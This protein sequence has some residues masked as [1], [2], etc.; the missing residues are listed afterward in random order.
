M[1]KR[2]VFTIFIVCFSL[3]VFFPH[4]KTSYSGKYV[5]L[6]NTNKILL[7]KADNTFKLY[8]ILD[9]NSESVEGKYTIKDNHI[10]LNYNPKDKSIL[11]NSLLSGKILGSEIVFSS[12][13]EVYKDSFEKS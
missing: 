3:L 12:S 1:K 9:K 6:K 8:Y 5:C 7:L 2:L 13:D 4:K 10:A 11:S